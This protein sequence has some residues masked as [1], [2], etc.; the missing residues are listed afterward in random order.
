MSDQS[1]DDYTEQ[2]QVNAVLTEAFEV[3]KG[4]AVSEAEEGQAVQTLAASFEA[5][6][7]HYSETWQ[8]AWAQSI[9]SYEQNVQAW[10][11]ELTQAAQ[12]S[13]PKAQSKPKPPKSET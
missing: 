7:Q 8:Q 6:V 5:Y 12:Q 3:S 1:S 4:E 11:K 2:L 9:E 13:Q 10:Q